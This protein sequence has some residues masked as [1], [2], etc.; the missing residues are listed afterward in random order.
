MTN[1]MSFG[2]R[3]R[4]T[5]LRWWLSTLYVLS[6]LGIFLLIAAL[7]PVE[8]LHR[9][10]TTTGLLGAVVGL[11][12]L[13]W[14]IRMNAKGTALATTPGPEDD[15][16]GRRTLRIVTGIV[17]VVAVLG[18]AL[19]QA[20]PVFKWEGTTLITIKARLWEWYIEDAAISFAY[21][22]NWANGD[23][24]VA[25]PGGERIEGYSNPSWVA[26]MAL[27][28]HLGVDGF[29]SSKIMALVFSGYTIVLSH[30][31]AR[32]II[33][34][35]ESWA[36]LAAPIVLSAT[37]TFAF[38][39]ASGLENPIV[40]LCLAGGIWRTVVEGKRGGFPYAAIWFLGLAVS[41]PE[42]I[43]Y[44][45]WGGL[46]AMV[47]SV[48][49]GRGLKPT[50]IWLVTFFVPFLG[51]HAIRYQYFAHLFP[52][53]YYA[54]LGAKAFRPFAWGGR[55]WKQIREW[56]HATG[57]G[58]FVPVYVAGLVGLRG[59]R[60]WWVPLATL[61]AFVGFI[62]P[63]AEIAQSWSWWPTDLPAPDWWNEARVWL[64]LGS[65][66]MLPIAAL[67]DRRS[68]GRILCFGM[69]LIT[70]FFHVRSGGDWM[71]GF[72]WMSFVTVPLSVLF[73]C[74]LEEIAGFAQR[75]FGRMKAPGW[76][77]PGWL[78]ATLLTLAP[79]YGFYQHSEWFF[80]KRETGPFSVQERA[81]YTEYLM[82][83][84]FVHDRL[85]RNLDVDMGAHLYW[86]S[87]QMVDMAGLVDVSIA[88]HDYKHRP[89]TQEYVFEERRPLVAH[90]HGGW[91]NTSRIPT[92]TEWTRDYI[93]VPGF[94]V[95][96]RTNHTGNHVRRDLLMST[97]WTGAPARLVP[98]EDGIVLQGFNLPSPEI[99]AG[100][101]LYIEVG[102][103]YRKLDDKENFR[104]LA[105]LSNDEGQV[106]SFDVPVGYDWLPPVEWRVGEI[107]TTRISPPTPKNLE[108]GLYDLGF[109][110]VGADGRLI[111]VAGTAGG[112]LPVGLPPDVVVGGLGD[113]PARFAV[114]EV[115]FPGVVRIGPAGTSERAAAEDYERAMAEAAEG[116]C[117]DAEDSWTLARLHVPR[118]NGWVAS[119]R[120]AFGRA[121]ATCFAQQALEVAPHDAVALLEAARVWDHRAPAL[122]VAMRQV[123]DVLFQEGLVAREVGAW[124][125]AYAAFDAAVRAN[126]GLSWARRYAEETRDKRLG[127]D[128]ETIEAQREEAR[129]RAD[130]RAAAVE[131]E[132][133]RIEAERGDD[134]G[135]EE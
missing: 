80:G 117:A 105:F 129:Q 36:P 52:N 10:T 128:E 49:A 73:A 9:P 61:I 70:F 11:G 37:S 103:Q 122:I 126:P 67:R 48:V 65:A 78:V 8:D 4:W 92:Y 124:T 113:T 63:D 25:F 1:P 32:E 17:L 84:L 131:A 40:N 24:L 51:Y 45:A 106:H 56:S 133:A 3:A 135:D 29:L 2:A 134:P 35:E 79:F 83:R 98:F 76:S 96:S 99:S 120:P 66:L 95:S 6:G 59:P 111:P 60:R 97:T 12:A 123:G 54:K 81:E 18:A 90:V 119:H 16:R 31:I 74:G 26:L 39:N 88:H 27:W 104:V 75:V 23:G 116:A 44:A 85:V 28:Y 107:G 19:H 94:P 7:A 112:T 114:G 46:V 77:T 125:E 93:G 21:A 57:I 13:A 82:E 64:L 15:L 127:I 108:P 102:V 118:A 33:D 47:W 100:K 38:W 121:Q 50:V 20:G 43:M 87:H 55:G 91:A 115:R 101:A 14:S 109:V 132:R 86:S 34:D 58:W 130:E 42:A 68:A 62:Y 89:F 30:A 53:T 41:R 72:R 69:M 5:A 71:K 110:V 22:R